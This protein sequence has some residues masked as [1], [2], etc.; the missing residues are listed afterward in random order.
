[1]GADLDR[2]G[3]RPLRRIHPPQSL[4]AAAAAA[5]D[6]RILRSAIKAAEVR[7]LNTCRRGLSPNRG[8]GESGSC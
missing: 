5:T 2:H 8:Q 1:M 6:I 4:L 7:G 3:G